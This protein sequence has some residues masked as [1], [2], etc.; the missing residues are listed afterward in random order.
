MSIWGKPLLLR[1]DGTASG[2]IAT[3]HG[4]DAPLRGLTADLPLIQT[5]S[6]T[7]STTNIR[8]II[9]YTG[10]TVYNGEDPIVTEDWS[11]TFG[12]IAEASYD[13]ISG[14]FVLHRPF[15][16]LDGTEEWDYVGSLS[17]GN[18]YFRLYLDTLYH[19][20][21]NNSNR[22]C[23]HYP[24]AGVTSNTTNIGFA[25]GASSTATYLAFRPDLSVIQTVDDWKAFLAAQ[26]LAGTPVQ[27]SLK[28]TDSYYP[29][30]TYQLTPHALSSLNG[31]NSIRAHAGTVTVE[32]LKQSMLYI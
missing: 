26:K 3:F 8:P 18:R 10:I 23:S 29:E 30:F 6:G 25:G 27:C 2:P 1:P 7:P 19:A 4:A 13:A 20:S 9:P 5:G 14:V 22:I 24:G 17:T 11:G 16:E 31:A 32:Y 28:I 21:S 12:K 15:F